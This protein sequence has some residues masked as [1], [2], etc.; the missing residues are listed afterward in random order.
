MGVAVEQEELKTVLESFGRID[1]EQLGG[2]FY[3]LFFE[4]CPEAKPKFE[5]TNFERQHQLLWHGTWSMLQYAR[6]DYVGQL[7][8]RRLATLHDQNH[9]DIDR[10]FYRPWIDCLVDS[11]GK[12]DSQFSDTLRESW[13]RCLRPGMDLMISSYIPH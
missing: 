3:P 13:H 2:V 4:V 5:K 8:L 6:G 1:K 7:A 12:L 9:M 11:I 10:K